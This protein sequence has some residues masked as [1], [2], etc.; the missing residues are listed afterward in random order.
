MNIGILIFRLVAGLAMAAHGAQK[1]F[2]WFGGGGIRG[3]GA[4]LESIGF[5]P[6][7]RFAVMAGLSEFLSGLLLA[8]GLMNPVGPAL[9]VSVMLIAIVTVHLGHGFFAQNNGPEL[10]ILYIAGALG[11]GFAGPGQYS[12]D[13]L[14]GLDSA[15]PEIAL[16]IAFGL[17]VVGT[18]GNL[19]MRHSTQLPARS[20]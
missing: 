4:F 9:M 11:V 7:S 19:A 3:T 13:H 20:S 5:R 10:A 12:L 18:L 16:W 14:L 1:L 8:L 15:I 17:S 6:G 2:G